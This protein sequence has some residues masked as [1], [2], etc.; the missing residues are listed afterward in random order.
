[1][2]RCKKLNK[3]QIEFINKLKTSKSEVDKWAYKKFKKG[4]KEEKYC[5][6]GIK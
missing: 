5:M 4:L 2:K 1:M 6:K 3:K